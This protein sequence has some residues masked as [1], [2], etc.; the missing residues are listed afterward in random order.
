MLFPN[1]SINTERL[2]IFREISSMYEDRKTPEKK[3]G[4][5]KDLEKEKLE[6]I[7]LRIR[8]KFYEREE[9]L[10]KV[11]REIMNKEINYN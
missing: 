2:I 3:D 4:K 9:V 1:I 6:L 5:M 11:V 8:N 10:E 7:Y